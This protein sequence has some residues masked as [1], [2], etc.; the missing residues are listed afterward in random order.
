MQQESQGK[1]HSPRKRGAECVEEI[2]QESQGKRHS[3]RKRG[4]D[5]ARDPDQFASNAASSYIPGKRHKEGVVSNDDLQ[6]LGKAIGVKWDRLA[7]RLPGITEDDIE[8]IEDRYKNLSQRGFHMLKLWK[9]N[10]G[11]AADYK[12]L[13]DALVHELVQRKDLAQKYCLE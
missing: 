6:T 4:A 3:P 5:L 10:N 12:T 1:R 11:E 7:R 13:Y 2:D 9:T 8:E